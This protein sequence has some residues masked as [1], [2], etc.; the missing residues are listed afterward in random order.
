[1]LD[2]GQDLAIGGGW[3]RMYRVNRGHRSRVALECVNDRDGRA[4]ID[5]ELV[6][7]VSRLQ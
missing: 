4:Q 5:P 6:G 3:Q 7:E 2:A 1:V